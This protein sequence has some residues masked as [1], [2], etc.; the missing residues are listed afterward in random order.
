MGLVQD[1]AI[2]S[3]TEVAQISGEALLANLDQGDA[4]LAAAL[5]QATNF[6]IPWVRA[7]RG[8]DPEK[9]ANAAELKQAAAFHAAYI[10]LDAQPDPQFRDRAEKAKARRDEALSLFR[11]VNSDGGAEEEFSPK[12]LPKWGQ[13]S[14]HDRHTATYRGPVTDER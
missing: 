11:A 13:T 12:G 8:L 5:V 3:A 9:V 10:R 6:L 14:A 4:T 7:N 2:V 1:V